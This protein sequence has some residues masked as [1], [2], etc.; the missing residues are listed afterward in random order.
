V[1]S[2]TMSSQSPSLSAPTSDKS[3]DFPKSLRRGFALA[4]TTATTYDASK[5]FSSMPALRA[6][7]GYS[8]V[9]S[10]TTARIGVKFTYTFDLG[11]DWT[12]ACEV[13]AQGG[14][15]E[16][17]RAPAY[18]RTSLPV[19]HLRLGNDPRPI[20]PPARRRPT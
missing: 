8:D 16:F 7:C 19:P 6:A 4:W 13:V 3:T 5:A 10:M 9:W 12:D 18:V 20:R 2:R 17:S 11:D 14:L 15:P 1:H